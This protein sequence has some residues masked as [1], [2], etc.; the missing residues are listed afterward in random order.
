MAPYVDKDTGH[1]GNVVIFSCLLYFVL[2]NTEIFDNQALNV[3][4]L[5]DTLPR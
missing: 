5:E 3:C 2:E 4:I 1:E